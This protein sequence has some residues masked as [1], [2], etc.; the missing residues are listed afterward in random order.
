MNDTFPI[1]SNWE[2]RIVCSPLKN[3]IPTSRFRIADDLSVQL[4]GSPETR[5][6]LLYSR[7]ARFELN[8]YINLN[9]PDGDHRWSPGRKRWNYLDYLMEQIPGKDNYPANITDELPDGTE[10]VIDYNTD[11]PIN[12]G[13]YSRFYGLTGEDAMGSSKH[14]RSWSDRYLFAAKT[15]STKVSPVEFDFETEDADGNVEYHRTISRWSYAIPLEII[16]QTPLTAWNPHNIAFHDK[17]MFD[18]SRSGACTTGNAFDGWTINNA[19]FTPASFFEGYSASDAADTAAENVCALDDG[20]A[21]QPVF[22]SGHW[23]TFP[24]IGGGVGEVR[25]RYPIFPIHNA[26]SAAFKEIKAM[27][28]V[29]LPEDYD[30]PITNPDGFF[31]DSRDTEYGFELYLMGGGHQHICYI[32]GWRVKRDWLHDYK[33]DLNDWCTEPSC[34]AEIECEERNG[35]SHTIRV[36][37][38][39]ENDGVTWKYHVSDCRF[40]SISDS[41]SF[42][43]PDDWTVADANGDTICAD[44]HNAVQR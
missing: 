1:I 21:P 3:D 14:R 37:R 9:D 36:W 38:D 5:E 31:G 29:V 40:G 23:V 12:S 42:V 28:A 25:Q 15:T 4:M 17:S 22:A 7:R 44:N 30:D 26:G 8:K 43:Y 39:Y 34:Y 13:Y 41:A 10:Q 32:S 11:E 24:E 2:Y 6:E 19:Y 27:Q 16:F 35:H 20:N 33:T 18:Y